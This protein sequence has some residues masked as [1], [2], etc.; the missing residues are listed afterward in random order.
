[1]S[2]QPSQRRP[3]V[4]GNW[5]MHTTVPEALALVD[6]MLDDLPFIGGV[7]RVLCPPFISLHA[8]RDRVIGT[9]I[10]VG[11]QN[12]YWEPHGAYTGE[13]SAAMVRG[14]VDYVIVGHSERRQHFHETDADVNRKVKAVLAEGLRVILCVGESLAE[15]ELGHTDAFVEAQVRAA[16]DGVEGLDRVVIAYEPIWAI[17]T[18][19]AAT[20]DDAGRVVAHIRRVVA[21]V[22]GEASAASMRVLYGGSVT[23]ENFAGFMAHPEIDGGLVGGASLR[24]D[25]FLAI[26]RQA[27]ETRSG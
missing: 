24:A 27:A 6:A 4:A 23:P 21:R 5:K 18:G 7:E 19:R 9:E 10:L 8:V 11:A 22:G 16:L 12:A 17:G 13:I 25:A 1:M 2:P 15:N 26:V 3:L 20:P 14:L